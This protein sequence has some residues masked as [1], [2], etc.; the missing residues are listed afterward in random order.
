MGKAKAVIGQKQRICDKCGYEN[1]P[2]ASKCRQCNGKRFAPAWVIAKRPINRQVSVDITTSNPTF[3]PSVNRITLSKWWPGGKVNFNIPNTE[4]WV[5]IQKIINEDLYPRIGWKTDEEQIRRVQRSVEK[6][7]SIEKSLRELAT[8]Y[9]DLFSKFIDALDPTKIAK[10]DIDRVLSILTQI[11]DVLSKGNTT[12]RESFLEVL[13]NLP[14]QRP[15]AIEQLENLLHS[16]TLQQITSVAQVVRSRLDTL[17]LFK[18]RIRDDQTFEIRGD[19]SIHRILENAMWMI[20][21]RYWLLSS[22]STLRSF[23]GDEMSKKDKKKFG[24]KRP[25]FVC[26]SIGEKL[27]IVEIKRPSKTLGIEDLNQLEDYLTIAQD[28]TSDYKS[29]EAYLIGNKKEKDLARRLKYRSSS[30][31]RVLTYTDLV[32]RTEKRYQE[33][34]KPDE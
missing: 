24:K 12:F 9:P 16:W 32:T 1:G 22:N 7:I 8:T 17:E 2:D 4:Q 6:R 15:K 27:I 29:F 13:R 11:L 14:R 26:G 34:F 31:F 25:D 18:N 28:Y 21:E 33:Y 30:I 23:I 10:G 5:A 19:N 20:D 3:G